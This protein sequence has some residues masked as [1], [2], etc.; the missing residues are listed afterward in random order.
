MAKKLI[1]QDEA[2]KILGLS[3]DQLTE[4]R[5]RFEISGYRDGSGWKFKQDDVEKLVQI[6]GPGACA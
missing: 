4:L 2:A 5:E 6:R 3:T 1:D